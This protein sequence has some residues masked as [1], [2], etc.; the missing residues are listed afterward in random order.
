[1]NSHSSQYGRRLARRLFFAFRVVISISIL[2]YLVTVFD[3]E[4]AK[5]VVATIQWEH[6]WPA[7]LLLLTSLVPTALR[8]Q[9]LLAQ[10]R[11]K[12]RF[13][14]ALLFYIVGHYYGI[15]L[16]GI[17]GGDMVRMGLCA[18]ETGARLPD[19]AATAIIERL[20]GLSMVLL[21][22]CCGILLLPESI[23]SDLGRPVIGVL[24]VVSIGAFVAL[25]AGYGITRFVSLSHRQ[26]VTGWRRWISEI[27]RI[28]TV[29]RNIPLRTLLL[30]AVLSGLAQGLDI[31]AS[32]FLAQSINIDLPLAFFLV[33]I[34]IVY[35]GTVLPISLGGLGVRE[36]ILLVILTRVGELSSDAIIL[37][38]LL[39]LN[40]V[41]VA[42]IG[43]IAQFANGIYAI[44]K[45][46]RVP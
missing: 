43:G 17:L 41:F 45:K 19:V 24:I 5:E 29:V 9:L 40:R 34:P 38:S 11:I 42:A 3:W 1:M 10:F 35:L 14:E 7:P 44:K 37:S 15:L 32:Y 26:N 46:E 23:R 6:A 21:I 12:L 4:R 2:V 31:G 20:F 36:G 22:G 18:S 39:Y 8:W 25:F 28:Y 30:V 13:A 27:V 16:P 33:A